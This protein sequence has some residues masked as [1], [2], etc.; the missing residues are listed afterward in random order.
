MRFPNKGILLVSIALFV[1]GCGDNGWIK[2][3]GRLVR[4]GVPFTL[5][6]GEGMR[7]T[8]APVEAGATGY[9]T[10]GA[11]FNNNGSFQVTG[12]DG[13]GLPPGKYRIALEH[14]KRKED[15]FGGAFSGKRTPIVREV[16]DGSTEIVIDLANPA[17]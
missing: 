15:L 5:N 3:R 9:D 17:S 6:P 13:K 8:F 14:L 1:C 4:N 16:T 10:Y 12:K 11:V 2:A 7:I